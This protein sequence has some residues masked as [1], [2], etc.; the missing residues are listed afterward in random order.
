MRQVLT[1]RFVAALAAIVGLVFLVDAIFV[2]RGTVARLAGP[3]EPVTRRPD[4]ISLVL[5]TSSTEFAMSLDGRA[6]QDLIVTL[7]PPA[8][9]VRIFA[10]TPGQVTCANLT[11]F[12]GCALLGEL[13]GDSVSWFALVP[14]GESFRFELPA[15][16]ELDGGLARLANG[17]EIPYAPTID[18]SR[19][20]PEFE[21]FSELL[22]TVG[23][24]HTALYDLGQR[25][26]TAVQC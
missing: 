2:G 21:S 12:G 1:W 8:A 19:C 6:E 22:R 17:W 14:M 7:P 5:E 15:I 11:A 4:L 9:P 16:V 13:L 20:E 23:R 24:D 3:T 18:R 26:I 25:E 10:G